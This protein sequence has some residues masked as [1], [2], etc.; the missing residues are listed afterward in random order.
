MSAEGLKRQIYLASA[1]PRRKD[2]L[3]EMGV[4]FTVIT[5][6]V[7]ENCD[8]CDPCELTEN[9]AKL[10]GRAVLDLL[11]REGRDAGAII[12]SADTV[13]AVDGEILGKPK[14]AEDARRM[15]TLM[16]GRAHEVVTGVG[17]TVDGITYTD[18]SVTKVVV[19]D[20]PASQIEKYIESGEP[21]DKAG[22]YGIQGS[23]SRWIKGIEGCYFGVVGL[24]T[25]CLSNLFF[26]VVGV[27]PDE[28]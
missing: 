21:F 23:F 27:Y 19:D 28:L 20:I 15:L 6:D 1:S 12:I 16:S 2:I 8:I 24:P 11:R 25:N 22:A 17:V 26:K 10:K 13:V 18:R 5:A 3:A 7:D 9:L 14:D 4:K